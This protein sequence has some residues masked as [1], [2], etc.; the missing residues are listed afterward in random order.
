[1]T[2]FKLYPGISDITMALSARGVTPS[3]TISIQPAYQLV[4][5]RPEIPADW[6]AAGTAISADTSGSSTFTLPSAGYYLVRFG[7]A[8]RN[9][10]AAA[11]CTV[12][13]S[14]TLSFSSKA[15][16]VA[17][18]SDPLWPSGDTE[19]NYLA[20][21][22]WQPAG[23]VA[24]IMGVF[25]LTSRISPLDYR[26]AVRTAVDPAEPDAWTELGSWAAPSATN[27]RANTGLISLAATLSGKSALQVGVAF[28]GSPGNGMLDSR[29]CLS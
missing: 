13:V 12:D 6:V 27:S 5:H 26:L 18:R 20:L 4:T 22:G 3:N 11:G 19:V 28:K 15:K 2:D 29:I 17:R 25:F 23:G 8:A 16:E 7:F 10:N 9:Q 1:V 14:H 24:N 21:S